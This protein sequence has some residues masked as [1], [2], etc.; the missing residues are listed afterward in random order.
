MTYLE[1]EAAATEKQDKFIQPTHLMCSSQSA[2]K[3]VENIIGDI[4]TKTQS[5]Q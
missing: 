2:G 1:P 5:L 4:W 3:D